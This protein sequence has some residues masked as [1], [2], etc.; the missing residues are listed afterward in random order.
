MC[1]ALRRWERFA[2]F[3]SGEE[4]VETDVFAGYVDRVFWGVCCERIISVHINLCRFCILL[5]II[6]SG[7]HSEPWAVIFSDNGWQRQQ[8]IL[9]KLTKQPACTTT[10]FNSNSK[11]DSLC[12]WKVAFFRFQDIF[13]FLQGDIH[14]TFALILGHLFQLLF[15]WWG[16]VCI[17]WP[18]SGGRAFAAFELKNDKCLW[19]G[20]GMFRI[21]CRVI[22]KL[23]FCNPFTYT[24]LFVYIKKLHYDLLTHPMYPHIKKNLLLEQ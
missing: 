16:F 8:N 5:L 15:P 13:S 20:V 7:F 12:S 9:K 3:P 4:R 24:A 10:S 19:R 6:Y 2:R 21:D 11:S 17:Y 18:H 14:V 1:L 22:K 23:I